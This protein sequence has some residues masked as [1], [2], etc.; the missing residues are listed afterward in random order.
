MF[1]APGVVLSHRGPSRLTRLLLS[2]PPP[3][4][5]LD[6]TVLQVSGAQGEEKAFVVTGDITAMCVLT[7]L[8]FKRSS[9]CIDVF[10]ACALVFC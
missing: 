1:H 6:T 2:C 4:T 8:H 3:D 9:D 10:P 7:G 5:Q